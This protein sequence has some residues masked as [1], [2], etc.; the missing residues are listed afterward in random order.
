MRRRKLCVI[1][2][3]NPAKLLMCAACGRAW[4]R[5]SRKDDGSLNA[6]VAWAARRAWRFA[7][8]S[9]EAERAAKVMEGRVNDMLRCRT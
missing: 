1:C 8:I 6:M 2:R 3:L 5:A 9:V 4:D 7:V